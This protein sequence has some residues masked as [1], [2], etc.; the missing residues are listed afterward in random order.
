MEADD[1]KIQ[2]YLMTLVHSAGDERHIT[3][4]TLLHTHSGGALTE[5]I[6]MGCVQSAIP[7][8]M[9]SLVANG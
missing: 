4:N 5:I 6:M 3:W 2:N 7:T 9:H 1:G 8:S